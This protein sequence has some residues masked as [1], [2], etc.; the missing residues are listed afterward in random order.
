[1]LGQE[2]ALAPEYAAMSRDPRE[3]NLLP[4]HLV[5]QTA[6]PEDH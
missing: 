5:S 6:N 1:V 4:E 2:V 3:G